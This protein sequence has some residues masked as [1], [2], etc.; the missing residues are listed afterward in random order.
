MPDYPYLH[1]TFRDGKFLAAYLYLAEPK[2]DRRPRSKRLSGSVLADMDEQGNVIGVE[3]LS[4]EG[5][6][7]DTLNVLLKPYGVRTIQPRELASVA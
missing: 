2:G 4:R 1:V 5:L 6:N 3:I 7:A